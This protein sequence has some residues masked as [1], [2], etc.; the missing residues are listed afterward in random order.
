MLRARRKDNTLLISWSLME[1]ALRER[2]FALPLY[3]VD[4]LEKREETH[5][6]HGTRNDCMTS[7]T[8]F[9]FGHARRESRSSCRRRGPSHPSYRC[10][11]D[12]P[13]SHA[14]RSRRN[15]PTLNALRLNPLHRDGE[16][17][18]RTTWMTRERSDQRCICSAPRTSASSP[19]PSSSSTYSSY[20]PSCN[21]SASRLCWNSRVRDCYTS[22]V[23][24]DLTRTS[25]PGSSAAPGSATGR[26]PR[27]APDHPGFPPSASSLLH[28]RSSSRLSKRLTTTISRVFYISFSL[29][30]QTAGGFRSPCRHPDTC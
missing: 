2:R 8:L 21:A 20:H 27:D 11:P 26:I 25:T 5:D 4:E 28:P 9:Y 6:A 16:G 23:G 19:P 15:T 22:T 12:A 17:L 7:N 13:N 14:S 18:D 1:S 24:P 10:N 29:T 30:T 3:S